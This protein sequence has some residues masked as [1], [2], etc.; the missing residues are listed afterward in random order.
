MEQTESIE[1]IEYT[2]LGPYPTPSGVLGLARAIVPV[3]C[4]REAAPL[5]WRKE[6]NLV[7]PARVEMSAR[8]ERVPLW[9]WIPALTLSRK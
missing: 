5:V 3:W 6:S 4:G 7:T 2:Y 8:R 9:L 1:I